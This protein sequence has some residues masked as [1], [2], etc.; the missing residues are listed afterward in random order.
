MVT[1][2]LIATIGAHFITSMQSQIK[3]Q[4][5][6]KAAESTEDQRDLATSKELIQLES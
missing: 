4:L 5:K 3:M 6:Y 2:L 1:Q